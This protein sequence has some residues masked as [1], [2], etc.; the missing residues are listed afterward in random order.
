MALIAGGEAGRLHGVMRKA[1]TSD[2]IDS[3]VAAGADTLAIIAGFFLATWIR[4]DSG[5]LPLP[6]GRAADLYRHYAGGIGVATVAYLLIFRSLGLYVRPQIGRFE[7][8]IPR[9][10]RACGLGLV[11]AMVMAFVS[12]NYIEF[13]TL[14]LFLSLPA[15][16]LLVILERY[17]CFRLELHSARHS[18]TINR[19][20][21]L[22]ADSVAAHL[23]RSIEKE[24]KLRSRVIGFLRTNVSELDPDVPKD[25]VLGTVDELDACVKALPGVDQVVLTNSSIGHGKIVEI[26]LFCERE[27]IQFNMVPDLF[28]IL[29]GTM[30][31]QAIDDIPLLGVSEWP[32][33]RFWARLIKR[34]EDVA[35]A[36]TGL[37]LAAPLI[38]V[39][40]VLIKHE[41]PGPI[42]FRQ[43]RCGQKGAPFL[44]FKL[45]TM[46]LDAE[47]ESGPVFAMREDPRVTRIGRFLRQHN[48]DELPQFWNVL[49]GE[50]SLV[51]PRPE[52]PH[53]VE[54]FKEDI[55][56]Y[57]WR[58]VS[59]PG[60]TG[61]AQ[62]NGL[63]GDTSI[64]ERIKYDLYYLENW[65]LAFDFKILIQ[66]LMAHENAY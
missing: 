26:I 48:L 5:W 66:T 41:S 2:A 3:L 56:R 59:K 43:E 9:I 7:N 15:V 6:F 35:G 40:A 4:F 12:K 17:I 38:A 55:G 18:S 11:A 49:R 46:R 63:R 24:P 45:R 44:L 39:A 1:D 54:R 62:V 36:V 10:V 31:M 16:T 27:M 30:D 64:E 60:L 57:M 37:L 21:I 52:R 29:T 20:L 51:G 13:S 65:S 58:H 22:G 47:S 50:M 28:R 19:V 53:F 14:A 34:V 25:L 61:W 42:L 23:K 33:D 8:K 32:L